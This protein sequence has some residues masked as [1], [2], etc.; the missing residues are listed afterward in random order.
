MD[1][2]R[3]EII[4]CEDDEWSGECTYSELF[5]GTW[6]DL[7]RRIKDMKKAGCY[8]ID[9]TALYDFEEVLAG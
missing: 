7:Q 4:W 5:D 6:T 9:A 3:Y 1:M 2:T 8:R